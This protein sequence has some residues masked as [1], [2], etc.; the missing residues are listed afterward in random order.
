MENNIAQCNLQPFYGTSFPGSFRV[1]LCGSILYTAL[2]KNFRELYVYVY[3][4][5]ITFLRKIQ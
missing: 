4:H 5:F 3:Q 2:L 1:P